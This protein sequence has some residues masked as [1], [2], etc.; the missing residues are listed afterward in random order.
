MAA[1]G[2]EVRQLADLREPHATEKLDGFDS[3]PTTQVE[4]DWLGEAREVVDA[5]DDVVANSRTND[6]TLGL[7]PPR[8]VKEPE[9]KAGFCLRTQIIRRT[10]CSSEEL[11]ASSASTLTAW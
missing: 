6:R 3:L 11:F 7:L 4:L 8:S 10:Q 1:E 9:P 5:Q 2:E